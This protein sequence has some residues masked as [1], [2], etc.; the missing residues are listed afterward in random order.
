MKTLVLLM[1]VLFAT[2]LYA[3]PSYVPRGVQRSTPNLFGGQ[4]YYGKNGYMGR[5]T[6]NNMGDYNYYG[7]NGNIQMRGY[8]GLKGSVRYNN[9][10]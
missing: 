5:S 3:G 7:R 1:T 4:N 6:K 2:N 9:Y 8:K 10:K